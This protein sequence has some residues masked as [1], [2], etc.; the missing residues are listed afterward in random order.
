RSATR[1]FFLLLQPHPHRPHPHNR[2]LHQLH[3]NLNCDREPWL[4]SDG[5]G[6]VYRYPHHKPLAE[7]ILL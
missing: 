2:P 6:L 4:N 7:Q 5:F 3:K 1:R